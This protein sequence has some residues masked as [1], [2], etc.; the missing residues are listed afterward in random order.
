M[1]VSIRGRWETGGHLIGFRHVGGGVVLKRVEESRSNSR[2][3]LSGSRERIG[4]W[5]F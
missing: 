3:V 2:F 4:D 5:V 1:G